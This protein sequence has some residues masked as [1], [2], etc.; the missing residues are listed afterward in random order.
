MMSRSTLL[1]SVAGA[2]MALTAALPAEAQT[3]KFVSWQV[4]ERGYGDW[5]NEV[6]AEFEAS[7]PGVTIEFTKVARNEYAD[8]MTTLFASGSPPDIVHL[9][10][11]EYQS[12]AENG[13]LEDLDPWI[14]DSDLDL[15]S[16]AGQNKCIWNGS[17]NCLMLLYFG[18]VMAYNEELL[19]DAGIAVPTTWDEYLAASRALTQD[20]DGDGLTDQFGTAHQ[21]SG[22]NQYLVEMLNYVLDA[23]AYWTDANGVPAMNSPEMVEGL[24]RWK[25]VITEGLTPLDLSAGDVRQ[26]FIEGSVALRLDGPWIYGVMQNAEA[27]VFEKLKLAA[28]PL[29]PPIGG[30]SN[31]LAMPSEIP[32]DRKQLVWDFI[33]LVAS[34]GSQER[35][36]ELGASPAPRPGAITDA[37][38]SAVPH[39]DLLLETMDAA[40]AAGVDRIPTGLEIQYNEFAK[41]VREEVQRM[42]IEDLDPQDVGDRLQELALALQAG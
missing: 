8:T 29:D 39:F 40:A 35:F 16:W 19:S 10:S 38:R 33:T 30:S 21:T 26:M 11:F 41:V 37:A 2:A 22:G 24:R 25:T 17:T 23:G 4:D 6:I 9:A 7:H 15:A 13:W 5:W 36:A 31:V 18:F 1:A 32:D 3:L 12:F 20:T 42:I 27:E 14:A 28:P 34:P